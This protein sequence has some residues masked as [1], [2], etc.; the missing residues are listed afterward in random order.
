M[1]Q[2]RADSATTSLLESPVDQPVTIPSA[3]PATSPAGAGGALRAVQPREVS[4]GDIGMGILF[5]AM[6]DA[7]SVS[8]TQ[9]HIVLWNPAAERLFGYTLAEARRRP[10][11]ALLTEASR[12]RFAAMLSASPSERQSQILQI[13]DPVEVSIRHKSGREIVVES[14][15]SALVP[16]SG[17]YQGETFFVSISR[18]VTV[19]KR[20]EALQTR[21]G[22]HA[23]LRADVGSALARGGDLRRLLQDC[24]QAMVTH[25]DAAF[26]RIWTL[27]EAK[28]VLEL[29][30]SAGM[31]T[32]VDGAHGRVPVG[33]YKIGLI[34]QEREPHLT[35]DVQHDPRVGDPEWARREGMVAFAGYP[36]L[37]DD[38]VIGVMAMFARQPLTEDTLEALAAVA[39]AIA[40]GIERRRAEETLARRAEDLS[41]SNADLEQFA[42]VASHDLQEPL[43][44]VVSYLQLLER[45][46]RGQLDERADRHIGYA[47]DGAKRMQRLI[48][49]LLAY[50]RVGRR[51]D[52][53]TRTDAEAVFR[54]V[55]QDLEQA[56]T[57]AGAQ[58]THDPLPVVHADPTQFAQLLQNL[59]A[60]A[61]RF[62][63]EAPPVAHVS[64]RH[65]D[66]K[67][68]WVF[69]VHD[70]GIGIDPEYFDRIFIIFQRLHG[71]DE[72]PGT[73]I[74]L[75][76]CKK[77]VERHGGRIWV[78]SAPGQGATFT[79]SI[80]DPAPSAVAA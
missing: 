52:I 78:E 68:E 59:I 47:V 21:Q 25:L 23:A 61:L 29:Q 38:R 22:R 31:Y 76:I 12:A 79:F 67:H 64:A 74:G 80:P 77:I 45:R 39:D 6:R 71:R 58:V 28:Q 73:G 43:R 15:V 9:S 13:V 55:L 72:Y 34:A 70:N 35:N 50:S 10:G 33:T 51:G 41:R 69:S 49:D 19:R 26:A 18:D 5:W 11:D 54:V 40:Q 62:R 32:H 66:E 57:D 44:M 30:A 2:P 48:N 4:P 56:I 36:L 16:D 46:Y 20:L 60:N 75:A 14:T 27:N 37:V 63:S 7:I 42:Y 17:P 3:A 53:Q 65:D 1:D 8:D 24:A